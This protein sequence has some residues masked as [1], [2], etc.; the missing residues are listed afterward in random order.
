MKEYN[1]QYGESLSADLEESTWT[2]ELNENMRVSAGEFA[3]L[4]KA[5]FEELTKK[6]KSYER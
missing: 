1:V 2:F 4:P 6:L 5:E 3:I